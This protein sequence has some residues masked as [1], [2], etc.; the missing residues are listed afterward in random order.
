MKL[1]VVW[2]VSAKLAQLVYFEL[3]LL[4]HAREVIQRH[5]IH[6]SDL[7]IETKILRK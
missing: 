4:R 7:R 2:S 1:R 6:A 3:H 5:F